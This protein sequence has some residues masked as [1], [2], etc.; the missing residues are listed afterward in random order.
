M[1][2]SCPLRTTRCIPQG[3][4]PRKPYNKSF[5]HQTCLVKMAGCWPR[6][7]F[8]SLWTLT[9]SWSISLHAKKEFG[10]YPAILISAWSMTHAYG[11][12][13]KK[14]PNQSLALQNGLKFTK[15]NMESNLTKMFHHLSLMETLT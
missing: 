4:F 3:K 7:F 5:I 9:S 8:V 2:L 1:E 12:P 11:S 15:R 14:L 13:D 6:S 10:Q